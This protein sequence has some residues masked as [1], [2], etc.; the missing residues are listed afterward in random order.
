MS[1]T[2]V[3]ITAYRGL[4]SVLRASVIERPDKRAFVAVPSSARLHGSG[5]VT[6]FAR[7]V[8]REPTCPAC[9]SVP[10]ACAQRLSLLGLV[11]TVTHEH[12]AST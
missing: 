10:S 9:A 6:W 5:A 8:V 12:E 1:R 7:N 4:V 2:S 3:T 11:L